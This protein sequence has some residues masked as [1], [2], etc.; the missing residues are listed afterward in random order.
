MRG[1][2]KEGRPDL[3]PRGKFI[4][5]T[6]CLNARYLAGCF[7]AIQCFYFMQL[8]IPCDTFYGCAAFF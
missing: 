2:T 8:F 4:Q 7:I 5:V 1:L 3:R 6:N